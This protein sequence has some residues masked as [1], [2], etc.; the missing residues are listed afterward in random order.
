MDSDKSD[1]SDKCKGS[2]SSGRRYR[3]FNAEGAILV[4]GSNPTGPINF[5]K[6]KV[7]VD[8]SSVW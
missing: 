7:Y 3:T 5:K 8:S 1:K 2:S 4:V 6:W